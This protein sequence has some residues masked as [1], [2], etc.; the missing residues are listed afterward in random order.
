MPGIV[1]SVLGVLSARTSGSAT[2]VDTGQSADFAI[3][4]LAFNLAVSDE[5]PYERATADFRKQQFDNAPVPGEQGLD[6]WWL[7][8]Q[9]SFH[10][11]SGVTYYEALE[12]EAILNR[13]S[14]GSGINCWRAGQV[15]LAPALESEVVGSAPTVVEY[16][17]GE[18]DSYYLILNSDGSLAKYQDATPFTASS[19]VAVATSDGGDVLSMSSSG[20]GVWL[21][22]GT[23]IEVWTSVD[24]NSVVTHTHGTDGFTHVWALKGRLWAT[25]LS[26]NFYMLPAVVS[27]GAVATTDAFGR[28]TEY[29]FAQADTWRATAVPQGVLFARDHRIYLSRLDET[30]T[31]PEP[32]PPTI[33]AELPADEAISAI[34]YS[35]GFVA[36]ATSKGIRFALVSDEGLAYGPSVVE[37]DFSACRRITTRGSHFLATGV[38]EDQA[39]VFAF[40]L[41]NMVDELSPGWV[42]EHPLTGTPTYSGAF[43]NP[44]GLL[45]WTD[46][47]TLYRTSSADLAESGSLLTGFHR[48]GTL[49]PKKFHSVR[50]RLAGTGGAVTVARVMADGSEVPIYTFDVADGDGGEITLS[51]QAPQEVLGLRFTLARDSSDATVGPTLLGYQLRALPTPR[52]QRLIRLPLSLFD[53]ERA[54]S[55]RTSGRSGDAWARLEALEDMESSG[56]T[57]SFRDFRTGEA[58]ECY[59]EKVEHRGM[60]PPGRQ[61]SGFGGIVFVTLRKL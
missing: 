19:A 8:S 23:N 25:D 40:D 55:G 50:V 4:D 35:L 12:G 10:R 22:N 36:I 11:G 18:T 44:S 51:V 7:R 21:V 49:E 46:A 29:G 59:I 2:V 34:H 27:G 14:L 60:T 48:F 6:G 54:A 3:G 58:G 47:G 39:G 42:L 1:G 15:T 17:K 57:F 37:G 38:T 31:T 13:F 56:G 16:V 33:V 61:D 24:T 41:G 30:A 53:V 9:L 20:D 45:L 26:G 43:N 32:L 5:H 52:R 28:V